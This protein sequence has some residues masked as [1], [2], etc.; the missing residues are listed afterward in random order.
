MTIKCPHIISSLVFL[1]TNTEFDVGSPDGVESR[2]DTSTGNTSEDVSSSSLH[3]GH[4]SF[5]LHD[6][7]GTVDGS[8]IFDSSST[9]HHHPSSDGIDGVGHEASSYSYT[10]TESEAHKETGIRSQNNWFQGVVETE[11]ETSVDEDTDTGDDETS[12]K[13]SNTIGFE[14]FGVHIYESVVL[15]SSNSVLAGNFIVVSQTCSGVVERVDE[16]ERH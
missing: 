14:G 10:I 5:V 13:T 3:H 16:A 2:E 4:E 8:G 1:S 6:L 9:G 12:V 15:T 7:R 11:V